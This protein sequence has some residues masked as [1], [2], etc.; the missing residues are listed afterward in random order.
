M[1]RNPSIMK[2]II[3]IDDDESILGALNCILRYMDY[4]VVCYTS[5]LPIIR[6]DFEL[7][8]LFI[9][10]YHMID[11]SGLEVCRFL[12]RQT[13]TRHIPILMISGTPGI[14]SQTKEA[15][16]DAFLEKPFNLGEFLELISRF[17]FK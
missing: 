4:K 10:D 5:G 16:A 1:M 8:D 14:L 17:V 12:K 7:P 9:I 13:L 6:N 11:V 2:K 3:V 15:G